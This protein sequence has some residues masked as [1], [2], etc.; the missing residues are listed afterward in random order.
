MIKNNFFYGFTRK[1]HELLE[2]D[3]RPKIVCALTGSK[4]SY[5]TLSQPMINAC[6]YYARIKNGEIIGG[7]G[8][9]KET[10]IA[11]LLRDDGNYDLAVCNLES[12]MVCTAIFDPTTKTVKAHDVIEK[13]G[14]KGHV[15]YLAL[16]PIFEGEKDFKES[17][18]VLRSHPYVDEL[19]D[20]LPKEDV[21]K[22]LAIPC[23]VIYRMLNQEMINV[24]I[25]EDLKFTMI[26]K[27]AI[28]RGAYRPEHIDAGEIRIFDS[29]SVNETKSFSVFSGK[30]AKY[31]IKPINSK[32]SFTKDEISLIPKIPDTFI[33]TEEIVYLQSLI[34]GSTG[35][36]NPIRTI[37]GRGES[38]AGKTQGLKALA[39]ILNLPYLHFT[40]GADTELADLQ[41]MMLPVT[42]EDEEN[43]T[44]TTPEI[45]LPDTDDIVYD[46]FGTYE[47]VFDKKP[48]GKTA[49]EVMETLFRYCLD[50][51]SKTK[52]EPT[53]TQ[54]YKFT[55][56]DIIRAIEHGY[57]IEIQEP[58]AILQQGVLVSLNSVTEPDGSIRLA[59][60]KLIKR[61]PDTIISYTTNV[62]YEGLRP[63]NQ[64]VL[65][66]VQYLIEFQR[67]CDKALI[68]RCVKLTGFK[69]RKI[70]KNML[71]TV[72]EIE[73]LCRS[74][75]VRD[76]IT[77]SRSFYNWATG[78][79]ILK[80]PY[81]TGI[82]SVVTKATADKKIQEDLIS[83]VKQHFT[84]EE[85][86]A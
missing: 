55:D 73:A 7:I 1:Y 52:Q 86:I 82:T 44:N 72:N 24:D 45:R 83:I 51:V 61:H 80:S 4:C 17:L 67:P 13:G 3:K 58:A 56:T 30:E 34:I 2:D 27:Q 12:G 18:N 53:G 46:P 65:D 64:S 32:R 60:G 63:I 21:I 6:L 54:G 75:K 40:C 50:I 39:A 10:Y 9:I 48:T 38:G 68:D 69:N 36:G 22:A 62:D 41:G 59:N 15:I 33:M 35:T 47:K 57:V 31:E 74:K 42:R 8:H 70:L 16:M 11:E 29:V 23:D 71:N 28:T 14:E 81:I 78:I 79:R 77:G 19:F 85:R 43:T 25:P 37:M 26:K 84:P 76:G 49:E 5:S 66:R 20:N